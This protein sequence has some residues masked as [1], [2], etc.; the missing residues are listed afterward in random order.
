MNSGATSER[1]YAALKDRLLA[2][3]FAP[4]ARLDPAILAS[5]L[6][7]SV[8]PVRE[9]LHLLTG[10]RL[11]ET[12][13]GDGFHLPHLTGPGLEDLYD[14]NADILLLSL[15][16]RSAPLDGNAFAPSSADKGIAERTAALF[17]QVAARSANGEHARAAQSLNDRLNA[18]RTVEAAVLADIAE[19]LAAIEAAAAANEIATLRRAI[20]AYHRRRRRRAFEIVRALYRHD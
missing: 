6:A 13:A 19:E 20:G 1:V 10:E 5:D 17:G 12:R 11:V 14:W 4:G 8:T 7:S 3:A 15:R 9:T 16:K 18:I 2:N